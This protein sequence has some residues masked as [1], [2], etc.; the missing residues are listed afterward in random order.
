MPRLLIAT[1]G[2]GGHIFPAQALAEGLKGVEVLFAGAHL[3]S[4][5][6]FDKSRFAFRDVRSGAGVKG[7]LSVAGGIVDSVRVIRD[8]SPDLIVGF[9]SYHSFPLLAAGVFTRVPLVLWAADSVPGRVIRWFSPF[10]KVTAAQFP[11]ASKQ[12]KGTTC[13]ADMPLRYSKGAIS[14]EEALAYYELPGK[15]PVCLVFGG[16]QGA[17]FLNE[18]LP[19]V[20]GDFEVIH[21][22][23]SPQEAARINYASFGIKAAVKPFETR[24]EMAWSAA[25]VACL[26]AGAV[27]LA[28]ALAFEVPALLIPFPHAMDNHQEMNADYLVSLGVAEKRLESTLKLEEVASL[29]HSLKGRKVVERPNRSLKS[30]IMDYL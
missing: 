19:Q 10:A 16:S 4:N 23:G 3:S 22:A 25:D 27:T 17:R 29:L 21:L 12:L 26:R 13:L 18:K 2:T 8:F 5:R 30:V 6:Y 20:L 15:K 24:M 14:K 1:G 11:A 9:G 7:L 28:E